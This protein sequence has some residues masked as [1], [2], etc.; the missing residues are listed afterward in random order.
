M[1]TLGERIRNVRKEHHLTQTEF[2][3][4]LRIS[5]PH[6]TNIENNKE[7]PSGTLVRLISVLFQVDE[8]WIRSGCK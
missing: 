8:D 4:E 1:L 6:V 3:T 5:R 2:A 7:N